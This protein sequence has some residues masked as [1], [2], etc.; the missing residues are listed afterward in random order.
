M[1]TPDRST[2]RSRRPRVNA[3]VA[4]IIAVA[5]L[6]LG[7]LFLGV[8]ERDD[9]VLWPAVAF[10]VLGLVSAVI[11]ILGFRVARGG[12]GAAALAAPIRVLSVLAFVIGAGGAVLGVASGVSQGSFA[13]VSVGFLPFLL[14]LSIMLQGAPLYGAAE[15][16]A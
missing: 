14:S 1:T 7:A 8:T 9:A 10:L 15:H 6:A 16:S 11:G 4:L 2:F 13:A 12:E 5:G 3:I